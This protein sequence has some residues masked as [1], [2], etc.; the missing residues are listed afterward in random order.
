MTAVA[1]QPLALLTLIDSALDNFT[2]YAY[3]VQMKSSSAA[4]TVLAKRTRTRRGNVSDREA[5]RHQIVEAALRL[6]RREPN[7][8]TLPALLRGLPYGSALAYAVIAL[9][10]F[11]AVRAHPLAHVQSRGSPLAR[12]REGGESRL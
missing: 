10:V 12:G 1:S 9:V 8:A 5:L 11:V 7:L 4:T 6:H 2:E 3:G